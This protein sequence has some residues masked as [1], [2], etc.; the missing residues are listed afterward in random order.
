MNAIFYNDEILEKYE[1]EE[2]WDKS[3]EYLSAM[4]DSQCQNKSVLYRF[5]A[6]CWYVLTFWDCSMPK[7][8]LNKVIFET[9]LT[10]AYVLA[11]E[12]WWTDSNCLWLFGY[13]MCINQ[14]IFPYISTDFRE[15]EREGNRLI[16]NAYSNNP[17]NQLA[18]VLYLAD[19]KNRRKYLAAIKK[20]KKSIKMYFPHQSAVDQY[21]AEIFSNQVFV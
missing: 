8:K 9:S 5:A 12:K 2:Q 13:F 16:N 15:V 4:V 11:K 1:E 20:I 14:M 7:D 21:F 3:V 6:Q 17:N 19:A 18:E 10:K